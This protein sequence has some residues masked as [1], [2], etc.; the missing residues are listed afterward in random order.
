[1][2]NGLKPL[3]IERPEAR[4]STGATLGADGLQ[5]L[6]AFGSAVPVVARQANATDQCHL[7][8]SPLLGAD[9]MFA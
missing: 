3:K 8:P 5:P 6:W 7:P 2:F 1:M 4:A 9:A